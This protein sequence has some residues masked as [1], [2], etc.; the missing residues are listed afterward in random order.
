MREFTALLSFAT[1]GFLIFLALDE[2]SALRFLRQVSPS[3]PA[4][5][6]SALLLVSFGILFWLRLEQRSN[7]RK[8]SRS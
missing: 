5:I 1:G 6:G 2:A 7:D 8:Q 4:V 3:G